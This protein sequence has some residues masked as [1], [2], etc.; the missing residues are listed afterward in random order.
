M[1]RLPSLRPRILRARTV[2]GKLGTAFAAIMAVA[3]A[4]GLAGVLGVGAVAVPVRDAAETE[5]PLAADASRLVDAVSALEI[6]ALRY[7]VR[8]DRDPAAEERVARLRDALAERAAALADP[9]LLLS[10]ER[11]EARLDAALAAHAAAAALVFPMDGR[12][13]ALE[14]FLH[15]IAAQ[16]AGYLRRV[17]EAA[18]FGTFEG[19]GT[20]PQATMFALWRRGFRTDDAALAA[21]L[22]AYGEQEARLLRFVREAVIANPD[23]AEAQVVRMNTRRVPRLERALAAATALASERRAALGGATTAAETAL[24]TEMDLLADEVRALRA[25]A[26]YRMA[27]A[28]DGAARLGTKAAVAVGAALLLG[29]LAAA[30]GARFATRRI[31]HPL[32][33]LTGVIERLAEGRLD[34]RVPSR[35]RYDE[36]G[37]IARAAETFRL[38]G[39]AREALE[40]EQAEAREAAQAEREARLAAERE[41][42]AAAERRERE[43]RAAEEAREAAIREETQRERQARLVEQDAV[44]SRLALALRRLAAGAL[45][46]RIEEPFPGGMD[47]LRVDFNDAVAQLAEAIGAISHSTAVIDGDVGELTRAA[48][49]LSRRTEASA[50][51][52]EEAAAALGSLTALVRDASGGADEAD[53]VVA[54]ARDEAERSRET[55]GE[56]VEAMRR[57][58]RSAGEVGQII[59]A[60]DDIA[61]QTNLLAL[62]AGVEAARAGEAGRGFAVVAAEVRALA[63]RSAE[64]AREI[65][66]LTA[67]S[68]AQVKA[69]VASVDRV[70]AVLGRIVGSVGE[71]SGHVSGIAESCREQAAGIEAINATVAQLDGA[72]QH[73]A[74]MFEETTASTH[75]LAREARAL[76]GAVAR[77]DAAEGEDLAGRP[78]GRAA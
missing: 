59:G 43:A 53:A 52:L 8:P 48:D 49:E 68:G 64:A 39:L 78:A 51:S 74:A 25:T 18:R 37:A 24:K 1:P 66:A 31:A 42:E 65:N 38:H 50:A 41:A 46:E 56:A 47:A 76:A 7:L 57:I 10:H 69:G 22:D 70:G 12:Q 3:G 58:E 32:V 19:I 6:A 35:G 73:N 9:R 5:L 67:Q 15:A 36:V 55:V 16:N 60:I 21:R 4:V 61:F 28:V 75:S 23:R 63:A 54:A 2:G 26:M 11:V 17:A 45:T 40:R 30:L 20:S 14:D 71:I 44:V 72:T 34:A 62:N 33:E 29:L 77:F 27:D 13:V